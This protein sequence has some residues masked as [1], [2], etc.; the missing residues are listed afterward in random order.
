MTLESVLKFRGFKLIR[1][2][3]ASNNSLDS[4][5]FQPSKD[6]DELFHA[7][8]AAF[9]RGKTHKDRM[10]EALIEYLVYEREID[11]KILP[12]K[13]SSDAG[14]KNGSNSRTNEDHAPISPSNRKRTSKDWDGMTVVWKSTSGLVKSQRPKRVMTEE[15]REAYKLRRVRGACVACKRKK[16]K[17]LSSG[18]LYFRVLI[19][20]W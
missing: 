4:F 8:K 7:L 9:P 2:D 13:P 16:K 12:D 6:S 5:E 1:N 18:C 17:V 3:D 15:Q 14:S 11:S 20:T 10:R 19:L